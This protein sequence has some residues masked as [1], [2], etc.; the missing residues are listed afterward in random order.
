[1]ANCSSS[2]LQEISGWDPSATTTVLTTMDN[3]QPYLQADGGKLHYPDESFHLNG[4][5][6]PF[7]FQY[8]PPWSFPFE[9]FADGR[10]ASSSRSHSEA[11]KRRRDRIN[12]QL[13]TLRRLI[14]RSEKMDKAAL[15][16]SV[17]EKVKDMKNKAN[18]IS[19][20]ILIPTEIDEVTIDEFPESSSASNHTNIQLLKT[21]IC[22][23]D[24]TELF[25][26]LK[27]ALKSL[28]LNVMHAD[29]VSL[30]GRIKC[31][32]ILRAGEGERVCMDTVKQSLRVALTEILN[33][34]SSNSG[35]NYRVKSRRQRFFLPSDQMI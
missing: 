5:N 25:S 20:V 10:A 27:R 23:D 31:V 33:T 12:A 16:G 34:C 2:N 21:S 18:E 9:G 6:Y 3:M 28:R 19:K 15:L 24:R 7:S 1:M 22:C 32:F 14:P 8:P 4:N 26:E 11:E 29:M 35:S 30:G 17:V 13:A